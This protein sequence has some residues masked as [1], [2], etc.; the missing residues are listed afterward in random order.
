MPIYNEPKVLLKAKLREWDSQ[1]QFGLNLIVAQDGLEERDYINEFNCTYIHFQKNYGRGAHRQRCLELFSK[2]CDFFSWV[3]GDDWF[4]PID[5][6]KLCLKVQSSKNKWAYYKYK[7]I[8]E[9]DSNNG[10]VE[11]LGMYLRGM[12]TPKNTYYKHIDIHGTVFSSKIDKPKF[13]SV[14]RGEDCFWIK[15]LIELN[16]DKGLAIENTRGKYIFFK[17]FNVRKK[18]EN[19]VMLRADGYFLV[20]KT[21]HKQITRDQAYEIWR[22]RHEG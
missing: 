13:E 7:G 20:G 15:E 11:K 4:S 3:D 19:G 21:L 8:I 14:D 12:I 5:I 18:Y 9:T 2:D 1:N 10:S 17:N 22:D 16:K 6:Y